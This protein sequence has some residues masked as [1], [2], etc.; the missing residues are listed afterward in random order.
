MLYPQFFPGMYGEDTLDRALHI[1]GLPNHKGDKF[2]AAGEIS[3]FIRRCKVHNIIFN[4]VYSAE[5]G[6]DDPKPP[7]ENAAAIFSNRLKPIAETNDADYS[8]KNGTEAKI[9]ERVERA[10]EIEKELSTHQ[11]E[12]KEAVVKVRVKQGEFR[13]RLL[14]KYDKCCLCGVS[15]PALLVASHIKP[16]SVCE[17]EERLDENNGFLLCPNHD[18]LFDSGLIS[19]EDTGEIIISNELSEFDK[20]FMN[21]KPSMRIKNLNVDQRKFLNYHRINVFRGG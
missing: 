8:L 12:G 20:L 21:I 16:W 6:W 7:C 10:E 2:I 15:N 1:L 9:I 17:P 5:W 19:F 4:E 3:L 18:K 13:G 14:L 11:L